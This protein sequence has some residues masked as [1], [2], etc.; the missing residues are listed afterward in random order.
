MRGLMGILELAPTVSECAES[1]SVQDASYG[2]VCRLAPADG[3][4]SLCSPEIVEAGLRF[5][6][7]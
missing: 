5:A 2:P 4:R 7:R 3:W 6:T 1:E